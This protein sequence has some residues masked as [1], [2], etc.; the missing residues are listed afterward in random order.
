MNDFDQ[1]KLVLEKYVDY[2]NNVRL[3]SAI[4]YVAPIAKF[5]GEDENV[6]SARKNKIKL[7]AIARRKINESAAPEA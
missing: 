4:G 7:A 1:A 3:H 5:N 6:I 2:Y